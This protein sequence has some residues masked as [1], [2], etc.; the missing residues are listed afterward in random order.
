[1]RLRADSSGTGNATHVVVATV[2]FL[3]LLPFAYDKD[4]GVPQL[5]A[6]VIAGAIAGVVGTL[7]VYYWRR[8]RR[9]SPRE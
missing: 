6:V 3:V 9:S 1:M 4:W 2:L 8:V 7:V 5:L